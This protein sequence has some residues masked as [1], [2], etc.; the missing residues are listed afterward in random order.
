MKIWWLKYRA[1][2]HYKRWRELYNDDRHGGGHE[3]NEMLHG[4]AYKKH[5]KKFNAIMEKLAKIDPNT[6]TTR[7]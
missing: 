5:A 2:V 7:L 4:D 1:S 3:M 6:P